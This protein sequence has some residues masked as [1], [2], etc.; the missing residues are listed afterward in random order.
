MRRD[1]A[2]GAI[3]A[4]RDRVFMDIALRLGRRN[5]GRT[6]PNPAVGSLILREGAGGPVIVGRGATGVGGRPH[7]EKVA[8]AQA[9]AAAR[10]ATCYV[11]LEPCAETGRIPTCT[12]A[13]LS[14]G[15]V[16]VVTAMPD[17]NPVVGGKGHRAL[18]AAGVA[19]TTDLLRE[20]AEREHAGHVRRMTSGRPHVVLKQ[21]VSAD[22][23]IG[24]KGEGQVPISGEA[25]RRFAHLMRAEHD[26]I[27]VGSGTV[28]EDDPEL[29]CRLPGLA[30]RSP[31][32]IV[33]DARL[34]TP[35]GARLLATIAAA[36]VWIV[37][38]LATA[39]AEP[40]RAVTLR[41]AGADILA[42]PA[43]ADGRVDLAAAMAAL[44]AR[45]ITT[46]MVEGGSRIA[47][48]LF[49]ADLV[50]EAVIVRSPRRI[51]PTGTP[52]TVGG[53]L[54]AF[55]AADRFAKGEALRLGEDVAVRFRRRRPG[56]RETGSARLSHQR[57]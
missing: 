33:V 16:R 10:G 21:A 56:D 38:T 25:S 31:V 1:P 42:V 23:C 51:G 34:T 45:G 54:D 26:A 52:A 41:G 17:P 48:A 47:S 36:P 29:T 49:E 3:D 2:T 35:P 28:L 53:P 4:E 14:C 40:A 44:A 46:V 30:D 22:D 7:A 55:L 11:S 50:D 20:R 37:T 12:D 57:D 13:L 6:A 19:V 9:G 27:L 15:I 39:A 18:A 5:A 8:L 24:R 43:A 32:R